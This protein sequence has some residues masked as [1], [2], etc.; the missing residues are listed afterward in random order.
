MLIGCLQVGANDLLGQ[1]AD[2]DECQVRQGQVDT[3]LDIDT[4]RDGDNKVK[5]KADS[6]IHGEQARDL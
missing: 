2:L 6:R 4:S 1:K 5:R 3:G